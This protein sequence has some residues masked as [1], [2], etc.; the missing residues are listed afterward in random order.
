[1]YCDYYNSVAHRYGAMRW[2]A[3]CVVF[4]DHTHLLFLYWEL[5]LQC[6]MK[7]VYILPNKS[8][9]RIFLSRPDLNV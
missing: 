6:M 8:L 3:V 5:L 2:H 4:P 7:G 9:A 1:M